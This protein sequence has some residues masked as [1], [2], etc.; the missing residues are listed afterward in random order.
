M[1]AATKLI[2]NLWALIRNMSKLNISS[3]PLVFR[4]KKIFGGQKYFAM[5][6]TGFAAVFCTGEDGYGLIGPILHQYFFFDTP[7][8]T[9][10]I[11]HIFSLFRFHFFHNS[12]LS[13]VEGLKGYLHGM[14][15]YHNASD[16]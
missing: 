9:K 6:Q 13:Q 16:T 2:L 12:Q 1:Q 15:L 11:C 4:D 5:S 3:A 10:G 14:K 7:P 8:P